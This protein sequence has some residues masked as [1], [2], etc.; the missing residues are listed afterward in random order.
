MKQSI[1][2]CHPQESHHHTKVKKEIKS[3]SRHCSTITTKM[4]C[5]KHSSGWVLL[6]LDLLFFPLFCAQLPQALTH[7]CSMPGP[8]A[9]G[10]C[11]QQPLGL[12]SQHFPGFV[13]HIRKPGCQKIKLKAKKFPFPECLGKLTRESSSSTLP[14]ESVDEPSP[15]AGCPI[16][17][18]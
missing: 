11:Q 9:E 1:P 7:S 14:A 3:N 13:L 5:M 6:P 10:T 4:S 18:V 8:A 2:K 12:V 17:R 16:C 15:C